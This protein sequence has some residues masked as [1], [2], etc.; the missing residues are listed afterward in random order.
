MYRTLAG[1]PE[2]LQR[3]TYMSLPVARIHDGFSRVNARRT[4]ITRLVPRAVE[5]PRRPTVRRDVER[6]QPPD[7]GEEQLEPPARPRES[8]ELSNEHH[9]LSS[10]RSR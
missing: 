7:A 1:P 4:A 9:Q 3:F 5:G 10:L 8:R 2:A 6:R